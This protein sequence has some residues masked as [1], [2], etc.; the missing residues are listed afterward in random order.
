MC[1]VY[2]FNVYPIVL[3]IAILSYELYKH[4]KVIYICVCVCVIILLLLYTSKRYKKDCV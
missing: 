1:K 4:S 2:E 3:I